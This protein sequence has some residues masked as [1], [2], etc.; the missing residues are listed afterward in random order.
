MR[1]IQ[2][3]YGQNPHPSK[4]E[5]CGARKGV[6]QVLRGGWATR[7]AVPEG[8]ASAAQQAVINQVAQEAAQRGVQVVVVPVR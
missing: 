2:N 6:R 5:E 1:Y 7:L 3:A 4:N 8:S